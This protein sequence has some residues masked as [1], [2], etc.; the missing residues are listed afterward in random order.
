MY[1][2]CHSYLNTYISN[3][4]IRYFES[5]PMHQ[6]CFSLILKKSQI[7]C[8]FHIPIK[9]TH[10]FQIQ[11]RYFGQKS[12]SNSEDMHPM[13][14]YVLVYSKWQNNLLLRKYLFQIIC[15]IPT[16]FLLEIKVLMSF[17]LVLT[18]FICRR[19]FFFFSISMIFP[20]HF[21]HESDLE[22][23]TYFAC[24]LFHS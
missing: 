13:H 20:K 6:L 10:I 22:V 15:E 11:V 18:F 16:H 3:R 19:E 17:G 7:P 9:V 4:Y 12:A 21:C 5:W 24:K 8:I 2:S 23:C 1:I 14:R